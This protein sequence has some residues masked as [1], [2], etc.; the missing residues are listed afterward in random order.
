MT[1]TAK[2][3]TEISPFKGA[4]TMGMDFYGKYRC[5][6]MHWDGWR[7]FI[8]LAIENGWNPAIRGYLAPD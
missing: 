5:L 1:T 4:K 7:M 6:S 2:T 8:N 3:K